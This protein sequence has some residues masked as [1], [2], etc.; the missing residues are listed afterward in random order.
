MT[1]FVPLYKRNPPEIRALAGFFLK[2]TF[3]ALFSDREAFGKRANLSSKTRAP[4]LMRC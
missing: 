3:S 2:S 4:E 1:L